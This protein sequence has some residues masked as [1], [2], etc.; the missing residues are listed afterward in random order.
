MMAINSLIDFLRKRS[1]NGSKRVIGTGGFFWHEY[2]KAFPKSSKYLSSKYGNSEGWE[3]SSR[4][5]GLG[6]GL[7]K[8][9]TGLASA[10]ET[11]SWFSLGST[12]RGSSRGVFSRMRSRRASPSIVVLL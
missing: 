4:S 2:F 6:E 8:G 10:E 1:S 3:P 7:S 9:V 12:Q 5:F 11:S